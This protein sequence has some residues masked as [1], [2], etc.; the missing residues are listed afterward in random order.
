[1]RAPAHVPLDVAGRDQECLAGRIHSA[2]DHVDMG[3]LGIVVI[4][5]SPDERPAKVFLHPGHQASG[6][7]VEVELTRVFG[8]DDEAELSWLAGYLR[9]EA[10]GIEL[11]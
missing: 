5:C 8:R 11:V 1:M 9:G 2:N 6:E 3:M 10:L 4:D 7:G